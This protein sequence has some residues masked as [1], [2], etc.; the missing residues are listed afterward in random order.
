M[1]S[2][3][4]ERL[5]LIPLDHNLLVQWSKSGRKDLEKSLELNTNDLQFE[6]F[7][8]NEMTHALQNYWIPMTKKF[9]F[10]FMWYTNWEIILTSKSCSI[11]GIGFSGLPDDRGSTEIGYAI[12]QKYR[13]H[14][15]ATEAL[16][17]LLQWAFQDNDLSF[18]RAETPCD[19]LASQSVLIANQFQQIDQKTIH[20][21][22][23]LEVFT[24]ERH[25]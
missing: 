2:I 14:G 20:C 4:T 18:V 7:Y 17:A 12:D 13:G 24:W 5:T 25:R 23:P 16:D 21:P 1:I 3:K 6:P 10:D 8:E 15:Y 19:N 9:P 11:G 22:D